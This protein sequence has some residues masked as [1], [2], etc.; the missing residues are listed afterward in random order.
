[1]NRILTITVAMMLILV[2]SARAQMTA[3][4]VIKKSEDK[5]RGSTSIADLTMKIVRPGWSREIAMRAWSKGD[6]Y[7]L[8]LINAPARDK[9]TTFLKRGREIWNWQP[10]IER[11]I[12][13][14][15]SMM[16]QS[17]M[18][19]DFTNDDLVEQSSAVKDYTHLLTVDEIIEGRKC[20]RIELTPKPGAAVVW[21]K[22]ISWIDKTEFMQ[23]KSEFYDEEGI[24]IN[25]LKG[26][27]VR[28]LGGR[29]LPSRLEI[30]PADK[31]GQKT[32]MEYK[33]LEF[34]VMLG[35]DFFS[36]QNMKKVK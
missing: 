19:S 8:I 5:L 17:W 6:E 31:P 13:L 18:G 36:L 7:S 23:L 9:G 25:T 26:T 21:G 28:S 30:I 2:A 14:P 27:Q 12:K 10:S 35:D 20:Y 4:E 22:V 16:S 3:I 11:V 32:I 33:N 1:M 34:D 29:M 24:L 15:P